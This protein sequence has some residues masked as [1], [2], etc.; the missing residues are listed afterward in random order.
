M[1]NSFQVE[2][3]MGSSRKGVT[4]IVMNA[5]SARLGGGQTY[6]LNLLES[7]PEQLDAE[8]YILAPIRCPCRVAKESSENSGDLARGES[9]RS[10]DVGKAV[11]APLLR[12][13]GAHVLFCP[14]ESWV[15]AFLR[16][17]DRD[18]VSQHDSIQ[19]T[20]AAAVWARLHAP[21]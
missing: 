1:K 19:P 15:H 18:H 5:L 21:S 20:A 9:V 13:V 14:V 4:R 17:Q 2:C 10:S 8:I 6:V 11:L 3:N 16:M 12:R 7:L